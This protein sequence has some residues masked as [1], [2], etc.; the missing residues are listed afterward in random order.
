MPVKAGRQRRAHAESVTARPMLGALARQTR[1]Q[2]A[3]QLD[4]RSTCADRWSR[5]ERADRRHAHDISADLSRTACCG[6]RIR[7]AL[8]RRRR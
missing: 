5:C 2:N 4:L 1:E 6:R 8:A 3:R 7:I